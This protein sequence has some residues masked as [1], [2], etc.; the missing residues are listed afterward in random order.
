M[1]YSAFTTQQKLMIANADTYYRQQVL[2]LVKLAQQANIIVNEAF[3]ATNVDPLVNQLD[4]GQ[5]IPN[6]TTL[7]GTQDMSVTDWQALQTIIRSLNTEMQ[8]S[9]SLIIQAIGIANAN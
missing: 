2:K 7:V 6:S 3:I 4:V 8:N 9:L 5:I 1:L